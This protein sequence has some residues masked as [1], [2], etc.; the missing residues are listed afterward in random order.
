[1]QKVYWIGLLKWI[2]RLCKYKR[3]WGHKLP[4]DLPAQVTAVLALID[5]ACAAL[6]AYDAVR[7]RGGP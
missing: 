1:M 4:D 5:A 3:Q 2:R 6:E 7:P